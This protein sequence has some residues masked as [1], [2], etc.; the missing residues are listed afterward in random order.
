V[1]LRKGRKVFH[2]LKPQLRKITSVTGWEGLALP[3]TDLT[4]QGDFAEGSFQTKTELKAGRTPLKL[5]HK[6]A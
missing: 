4:F 2:Q 3:N 5:E 1:G 6:D